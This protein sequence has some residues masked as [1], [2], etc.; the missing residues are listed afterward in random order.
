MASEQGSLPFVELL[1]VDAGVF[2]HAEQA[3]PTPVV[4]LALRPEPCRS[5]RSVSL[6]ITL[7]QAVRLRDDLSRVLKEFEP[8]KQ[9]N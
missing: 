1:G 7:E 8:A 6:P 3:V 5:W 4:F 9:L 2:A